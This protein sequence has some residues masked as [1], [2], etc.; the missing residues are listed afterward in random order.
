[1]R[2]NLH[3]DFTTLIHTL[4][5]LSNLQI[6]PHLLKQRNQK[7][8]ILGHSLF[9]TVNHSSGVPGISTIA[10]TVQVSSQTST[11][12]QSHHLTAPE[13][14][15]AQQSNHSELSEPNNDVNTWAASKVN[16]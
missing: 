13:H 7:K 2:G 3:S 16:L 9:S 11:L 15:A 12:L 10:D 14:S 8:K 5:T 1:M 4:P 6:S